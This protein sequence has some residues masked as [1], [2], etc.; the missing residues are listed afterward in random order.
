M[1]SGNITSRNMKGPNTNVRPG[2]GPRPRLLNTAAVI[3]LPSAE[4]KAP[5]L[6]K[7]MLRWSLRISVAGV[8]AVIVAYWM[9]HSGF[10]S[11]ETAAIRK[12]VS[13]G[14]HKLSSAKEPASPPG[15]IVI[16]L[17]ADVI[18]VTSIALG[19]PRLAVINGKQVAEGDNIVVHTP[20]RFV[21]VTLRV[22]EIADR[23][24][25]LSDGNQL[26][27]AHLTMADPQASPTS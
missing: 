12:L 9:T 19:H 8:L 25:I 7:R 6:G 18:Q 13:V 1:A 14:T 26:M 4:P 24:V 10:I 17:S 3:P 15:P 27:V 22:I 11:E 2:A 21:A 23:R 20:T 16:Q 5:S